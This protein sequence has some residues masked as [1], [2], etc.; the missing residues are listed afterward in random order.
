MKKKNKDCGAY[1]TELA[2]ELVDFEVENIE[3]LKGYKK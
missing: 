1:A 3:R 2:N